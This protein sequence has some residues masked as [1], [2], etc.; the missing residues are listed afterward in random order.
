M[1]T[2]IAI[3]CAI[4]FVGCNAKE[5]PAD[6]VGDDV[7]SIRVCKGIVDSSCTT[8]DE[9]FA[10]NS[11]CT[12]LYSKPGLGLISI[13]PPAECAALLDVVRSK[14]FQDALKNP[15]SCATKGEVAILT[16]A[17]GSSVGHD[18]AGCEQRPFVDMR[19][20]IDAVTR[21]YRPDAALSD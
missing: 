15:G 14:A 6:V 21:S 17:S 9:S 5:A 19:N 2:L 8:F 7:R 10:M 3:V 18:I 20:A 13:A 12:Y 4:T 11:N 1:R 16:L